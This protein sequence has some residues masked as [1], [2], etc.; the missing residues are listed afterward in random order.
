MCRW[1][2]LVCLWLVRCDLLIQ[3]CLVLVVVSSNALQG[4][5]VREQ[6][7]QWVCM[8]CRERKQFHLGGV[9]VVLRFNV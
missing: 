5:C 7:E 6:G 2:N 9:H 4:G 8:L 3:W 1:G